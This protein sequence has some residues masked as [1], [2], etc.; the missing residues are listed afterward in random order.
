MPL[1]FQLSDRLFVLTGAGISAESGLATF[2]GKGGLWEGKRAVDLA[3]PEA[4]ARDPELVWRF[5]S[6]RRARHAECKPNPGHIALARLEKRLCERMLVCTQNVDSL[7]ESAGSKRVLHM[8]GKLTESRCSNPQCDSEP[9]E[10]RK[11]YPA[12]SQIPV[13]TLCGAMLRPHVCWFGEIPYHMGEVLAYLQQCTVF[14]TVGTSGM[15]QPAASFAEI[16][17]RNGAR[18]YY[19]GPENPANVYSFQEVFLG[20]AGLRLPEL[21]PH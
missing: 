18:T 1:Q 2:R 10:D 19:V 9:F 3:T 8:H 6:M 4:F 7:H 13:C 16:A 21:L 17:R 12:H 14:L 20:P 15:V 11:E 5:Y